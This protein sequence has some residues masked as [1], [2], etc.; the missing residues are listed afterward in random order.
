MTHGGDEPK[1]SITG[2]V[3]G[4]SSQRPCLDWS[5]EPCGQQMPT[6]PPTPTPTTTSSR[7]VT[8]DIECVTNPNDADADTHQDHAHAYSDQDDGNAN[9][10][11]NDKSHLWSIRGQPQLQQRP[12]RQSASSAVTDRT[13]GGAGARIATSTG[14]QSHL[15]N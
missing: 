15:G 1:K 10:T 12:G 11:C 3:I 9:A 5:A 7:R 2:W 14:P 6:R 8:H 13:A 4:E